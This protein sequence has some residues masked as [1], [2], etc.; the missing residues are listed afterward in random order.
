MCA[1]FQDHPVVA[2]NRTRGIRFR[3]GQ[4]D[5]RMDANSTRD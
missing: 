3:A 5:T 2:R 1:G 4:E